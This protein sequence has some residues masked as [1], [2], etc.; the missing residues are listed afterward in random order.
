MPGSNFPYAKSDDLT[1]RVSPVSQA[2]P[3]IAPSAYI[4]SLEVSPLKQV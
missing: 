4:L 3:P 2:F 1:G